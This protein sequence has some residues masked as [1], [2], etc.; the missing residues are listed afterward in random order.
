MQRFYFIFYLDSVVLLSVGGNYRR[1]TRGSGLYLGL[2]RIGGMLRRGKDSV[3]GEEYLRGSVVVLTAFV[4]FELV[5][6][7]LLLVMGVGFGF[8]GGIF[9]RKIEMGKVEMWR[10]RKEGRVTGR[11]RIIQEGRFSQEGRL[12]QKDQVTT[13]KP[14]LK[15][16]M[17][18]HHKS[19]NRQKSPV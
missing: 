14:Y 9:G 12:G 4:A 10:H 1:D 17:R 2:Q 3:P 8:G 19:R 5:V 16:R 13:C 7:G 18:R 15:A 6:V 11:G